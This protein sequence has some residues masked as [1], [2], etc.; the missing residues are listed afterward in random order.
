[1]IFMQQQAAPKKKKIRVPKVVN[2]QET[3]VEIEFDYTG[4]PAWGPNDGHAL[5]NHRHARVDGPAKVCGAARYTHDVRLPGMLYARVLR[6]PHARARVRRL[7][8]SAALRVPGVKAAVEGTKD[9]RYAGAP[10]AA[11]AATTPEIADD[12]LRAIVVEYEVLPHVVR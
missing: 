11:L 2:G 6:A 4:G 5:L 10:V 3:M 8:L 1:M 7:D 9:V 12:A